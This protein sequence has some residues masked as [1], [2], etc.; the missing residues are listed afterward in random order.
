VRVRDVYDL[1]RIHE[2]HPVS[3]VEFWGKAGHEFQLACRSRYVDCEGIG[4]FEQD[5][6]TT[7]RDYVNAK[8]FP[9]DISFDDAWEA[10]RSVVGLFDRLGILPC[11][12]PLP[13]ESAGA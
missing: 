7:R 12:Y 10:L 4:A 6:D 11:A 2:R 1:A 5:L 13:P 8:V 9:N 3:D